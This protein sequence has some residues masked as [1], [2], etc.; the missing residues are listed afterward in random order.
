MAKRIDPKEVKSI[1]SDEGGKARN[2][3]MP[4]ETLTLMSGDALMKVEHK[5]THRHWGNLITS[6]MIG[7]LYGPRGGGK[8]YAALG[9]AVAMSTGKPF[10]GLKPGHPRKVVILDGEMGSKLMKRRLKEMRSSLGADTL[11]ELL[12]L[13]PDMYSHVLPSLATQ[14]GQAHI[15]KIIPEDT[16]VIIVDNVSA[17]NRGGREDADGWRPWAEWLLMHKHLGRTVIVVHHAG[18]SGGQ[19][20]T[21]NREDNLDFVIKLKP[22]PDPVDADALSFT[23]SWDKVRDVGKSAARAIHVTRAEREGKAPKWKYWDVPTMGGRTLEVVEMKEGGMTLVEIGKKIG[24]D[25]S[26][27]SRMLKEAKSTAK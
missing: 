19:R 3:L 14:L 8:T 9:L 21:S 18:K 16:Q 22:T 24:K 10:L 20:G 15:D 6:E 17:W 7:M 5:P 4:N 11:G 23:L 2:V 25:K 1:V 26:T 13:T 27:V 12:L